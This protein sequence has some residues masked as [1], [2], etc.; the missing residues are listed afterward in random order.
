MYQ[1]NFSVAHLA[2]WVAIGAVFESCWHLVTHQPSPM[3]ARI[4]FAGAA[5]PAA[6]PIAA[7]LTRRYARRAANR[8]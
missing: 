6:R 3:W 7:A 1:R 2:V 8:P 5:Y 4:A